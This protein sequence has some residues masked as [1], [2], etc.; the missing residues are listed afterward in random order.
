MEHLMLIVASFILMMPQTNVG[1]QESPSLSVLRTRVEV[2]ADYAADTRAGQ[3]AARATSGPTGQ[4]E[5]A[6]ALDRLDEMAD[7]SMGTKYKVSMVVRNDDPRAIRAVTFEYPLGYSHAR[8][9]P[10]R[11]RFKVRREIKSGETLP[12]S[13]S[14]VSTKQVVL[15][16][17]EQASVKSIE[18]KDGSVWRH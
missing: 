5:T 9:P 4:I 15:R 17:G 3:S 10:E 1:Q 8:R 2:V 11:L 18:Y 16:S 13:H 7:K 14:F 12:L 6:G